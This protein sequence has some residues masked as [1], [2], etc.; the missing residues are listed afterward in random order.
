MLFVDEAGQMSLANV[1]A[2]SPAANSVVLLGDH[3]NS[4]SHSKASS[5][6]AELSALAHLLNGRALRSTASRFVSGKSSVC[7]QTFGVHFRSVLRW[8]ADNACG[9]CITTS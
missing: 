6:G 8:T 4:I 2:L 9:E 7:I 3:N 1:V 5:T